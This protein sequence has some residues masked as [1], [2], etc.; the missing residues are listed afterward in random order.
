MAA[1]LVKPR[2]LVVKKPVGRVSLTSSAN[3]KVVRTHKVPSSTPVQ[4]PVQAPK[5]QE[6]VSPAFTVYK[7]T[8]GKKKVGGM[9]YLQLSNK[10]ELPITSERFAVAV[11]ILKGATTRQEVNHRVRDLLPPSVRT[12]SPKTVSNLVS[13]VVKRMVDCGF[14][15]Q[16]EWRMTPPQG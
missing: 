2:R 4:K 5:A 8:D 13:A 12:K 14:T 11:E 10:L 3:K 6:S 7:E 16:G 15:V 1:T 9:S